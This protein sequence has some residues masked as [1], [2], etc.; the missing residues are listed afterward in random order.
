MRCHLALGQRS[1]GIATFER[2]RQTLA[3]GLGLTPTA[4]SAALNETLRRG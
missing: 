4:A 1:E 3:A 2:L